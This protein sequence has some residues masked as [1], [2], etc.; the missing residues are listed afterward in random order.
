MIPNTINE[1]PFFTFTY[2]DLHAHMIAF[3][4]AL[5]GLATAIA[6]VR[7]RPVEPALALAGENGTARREPSP[8]RITLAELAPMSLLGLVIGALRATNT[9]DFPTYILV[10]LA[11]LAV[12]EVARRS[13][14]KLLADRT[15][16]ADSSDSEAGLSLA[17]HPAHTEGTEQGAVAGGLA[18]A[19]ALDP[20]GMGEGAG[21][22]QSRS[23]PAGQPQGIR[24]TSGSV[25]R[26]P[27]GCLLLPAA[28]SRLGYDDETPYVLAPWQAELASIFHATIAVILRLLIVVAVAVLT[29]YPYTKYYA[30]AYTGLSVG[31]V[32]TTT[33][34]DFL[35]VHGF[36]LAVIAIY[37]ISELV[38]QLREGMI[39]VWLDPV[40]PFVLSA[41]V[42][43][44]AVG[45]VLGA[46]IWEIAVPLLVLDAAL[47]LGRGLPST[48]R[49]ALLLIALGLAITMGVEIVHLDG[50]IGRMNT[51]FK[52]Y[53]QA[54][55]LFGVAAA[56]GL[57][58]WAERSTGW[59]DG[60]RRAATVVVVVLFMGVMLYPP[61]AAHAKVADRFSADDQPHTLDGMAYMD[62]GQYSDNNQDMNLPADKA[63]AILWMMHNV[64]GSPVILEG[65]T[66]NYRWGGRFSIYTGLPAVMG[67]DYHERQQRSIVPDAMISRRLDQVHELYTTSDLARTTRLLDYYQVKYIIVGALERTYY[68]PDVAAKFDT[69]TQQGYLSVAYDQA[70]VRIYQVVGR[71]WRRAGSNIAVL[72]ARPADRGV[73]GEGY[74]RCRAHG[75]RPAGSPRM[76][77]DPDHRAADRHPGGWRRPAPV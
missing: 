53:L 65:N 72:P 11:A 54:W 48:R 45:W 1:F 66:P 30:T 34:P 56:F 68:G 50:D 21:A 51:V 10:A 31:N 75:C 61:L 62:N 46:E 76:A 67:W 2:A 20:N 28:F 43:L 35:V 52:F 14:R 17:L 70:G 49:L 32:G 27:V 39:A 64:K 24:N 37:L 41:T 69:L 59:S 77:A 3:P 23:L 22:A 38:V 60:W 63:A 40:L 5:L 33:I 71:S 55:I 57:A 19:L 47:A 36:F 13:P 74:D 16:A 15:G 18:Y 8:W 7:T 9:W 25:E 58:S 26:E 73:D 29:F 44:M 6:L 4:L 12:L 42:L